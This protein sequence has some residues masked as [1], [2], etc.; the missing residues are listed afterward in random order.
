MLRLNPVATFLGSAISLAL[1]TGCPHRAE[2]PTQPPDPTVVIIDSASLASPLDKDTY[3]RVGI[4]PSSREPIDVIRVVFPDLDTVELGGPDVADAQSI[5]EGPSKLILLG[6]EL[7][8]G[9]SSSAAELLARLPS[10]ALIVVADSASSSTDVYLR[11]WTTAAAPD[12]L[13]LED[14]NTLRPV[15]G[16]N[17]IGEC[18]EDLQ[19]RHPSVVRHAML[20]LRALSGTNDALV[21]DLAAAHATQD[22]RRFQDLAR[23]GA[24]A[25]NVGEGDL[26]WLDDESLLLSLLTTSGRPVATLE[27]EGGATSILDTR[28]YSRWLSVEYLLESTDHGASSGVVDGYLSLGAGL[29]ALFGGRLYEARHYL[30]RPAE[31]PTTQLLNDALLGWSESLISGSA[32]SYAELMTRARELEAFLPLMTRLNFM[33]GSKRDRQQISLSSDESWKVLVGMDPGLSV[34]S[35]PSETSSEGFIE[36]A[37]EGFPGAA[38]YMSTVTFPDYASPGGTGLGLEQVLRWLGDRR[39]GWARSVVI[40]Q[41]P[42]S[43]FYSASVFD[44]PSIGE[45]YA[46]ALIPAYTRSVVAG[47]EECVEWCTNEQLELAINRLDFSFEA[48]RVELHDMIMS[49]PSFASKPN[50]RF[51]LALRASGMTFMGMLYN[52]ASIIEGCELL[53]DMLESAF[54]DI[55]FVS[56]ANLSSDEN[57]IIGTYHF[58][59]GITLLFNRLS[60]GPNCDGCKGWEERFGTARKHF[61]R[62]DEARFG[63]FGWWAPTLVSVASW[64][65][66]VALRY[67][68][69]RA[70]EGRLTQA[71]QQLGVAVEL[72]F[73]VKLDSSLV[74]FAV[75]CMSAVV[76]EILNND[77]AD[78]KLVE[79]IVAEAKDLELMY[80]AKKNRRGELLARVANILLRGERPTASDIHGLANHIKKYRAEI[81]SSDKSSYEYVWTTALC[82]F[83]LIIDDIYD[84]FGKWEGGH[85]LLRDVLMSDPKFRDALEASLGALE[86]ALLIRLPDDAARTAALANEDLP[87]DILESAVLTVLQYRGRGK[88]LG[89]SIAEAYFAM[90]DT[91]RIM[92]GVPSVFAFVLPDEHVAED[93]VQI[94]RNEG[95]ESVALQLASRLYS[96][97]AEAECEKFDWELAVP[98]I[99][100][101]YVNFDFRAAVDLTGQLLDDLLASGRGFSTFSAGWIAQQDSIRV[102]FDGSVYVGELVRGVGGFGFQWGYGASGG[103]HNDFFI[104]VPIKSEPPDVSIE[105]MALLHMWVAL[106]A[107]DLRAY[108]RGLEVLIDVR[109][110]LYGDSHQTFYGGRLGTPQ[111]HMELHLYVAVAAAARGLH[112]EVVLHSLLDESV[113]LYSEV[114][115]DWVIAVFTDDEQDVWAELTRGF[116]KTGR[117]P[118]G[119]IA[120][121]WPKEIMPDVYDY[122]MPCHNQQKCLLGY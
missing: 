115:P 109:R 57:V 52:P 17:T 39:A 31:S 117:I 44:A 72:A 64:I 68:G 101:A 114:T 53:A 118:R 79:A 91:A 59:K 74:D 84:L 95:A 33:L 86:D 65:E 108:D 54:A 9:S 82:E 38:A 111:A 14:I 121:A 94:F 89:E 35:P 100:E 103:R 73:S 51:M 90:P 27:T 110:G 5:V 104:Q 58:A 76:V 11:P 2:P 96:V 112:D 106:L 70:Y 18:I 43:S 41:L 81:L 85:A 37:D 116:L 66:A 56:A 105:S 97:E 50:M 102:N 16:C 62:V 99:H 55:R 49:S 36:L 119:K 122:A 22:Y 19:S 13:R 80:R 45:D 60:Q 88:P 34:C 26:D 1:F 48:A 42:W 78:S 20:R 67:R 87:T 15:S 98:D 71:S 7:L 107:G 23:P 93:L 61:A 4:E 12:A 46:S 75:R 32:V 3:V 28:Q 92:L 8:E 113:R 30:S 69:D 83:A 25:L 24:L 47:F 63:E 120:K 21:Q 29:E 77:P 40:E 10:D 6:P